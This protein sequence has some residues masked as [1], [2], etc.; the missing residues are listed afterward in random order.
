MPRLAEGSGIAVMDS[1]VLSVAPS[2]SRKRRFRS[3]MVPS[4]M[5]T[6]LSWA[7]DAT[8]CTART[9]FASDVRRRLGT[10]PEKA[11][12]TLSAMS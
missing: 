3:R 11:R 8:T 1:E 6:M 7:G 10:F 9:R 5:T 12:S 4:S 2:L